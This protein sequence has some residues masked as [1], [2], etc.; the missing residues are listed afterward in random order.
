VIV[1]ASALC[2]ILL[3]EED[4]RVLSGRLG[5]ERNASTHP[6]SFY[7][8]V[9]ALARENNLTVAEATEATSEFLRVA[10]VSLVPIGQREM[11]MALEAFARY[12][13]GRHPAKLN[14]GDCFSYAVAKLR[15]MPLLYKGEDFAQTDLAQS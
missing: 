5:Q 13:K 10:E 12:G 2:A 8:A 14:M 9:T 1:D 11:L 15:G 7:E 3:G 6:I 4:S